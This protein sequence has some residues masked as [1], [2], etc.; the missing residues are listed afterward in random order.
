M[1]FFNLDTLDTFNLAGFALNVE[2]QASLK[3]SLIIKRDE[4]KFTEISLWGKLLGI[5]QDYF[6]AQ[7]FNDSAF[8]RKYFYRYF[9]VFPI[10]PLLLLTCLLCSLVLITRL[11]LSCLKS[12]HQ[13][14]LL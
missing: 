7:A 3:A 1:A 2:E 5:Q 4:E 10:P 8:K 6:I 9:L 11:G 13:T 12:L 14:W